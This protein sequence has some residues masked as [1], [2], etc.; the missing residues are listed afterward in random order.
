MSIDEEPTTEITT[1][2]QL[3][4]KGWGVPQRISPGR[5]VPAEF[6]CTIDTRT[7][8]FVVTL[9]V[10]VGDGLAR[11]DA[12]SL[13]RRPS[14]PPIAA[15][16][17]RDVPLKRFLD[18]SL[19]AAELRVEE[20]APGHYRLAPAGDKEFTD[21]ALKRA[22]HTAARRRTRTDARTDVDRAIA[23]FEEAL[24]DEEWRR[25]PTMYVADQMHVSRST[26]SR[27]LR[28]AREGN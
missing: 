3:F 20:T 14:G 18:A 19:A 11:I 28:R 16:S 12:V 4:G 10:A 23:L 22:A 15:R 5:A 25:K 2:Y 17:L 26:A 9:E 13:K 27:L 7:L 8:P 24:T 6:A 1:S 21:A